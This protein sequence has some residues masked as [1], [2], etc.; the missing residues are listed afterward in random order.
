M[1]IIRVGKDVGFNLTV[2]IINC[3]LDMQEINHILGVLEGREKSRNNRRNCSELKENL[4]C[5]VMKENELSK[6]KTNNNKTKTFY[7]HSRKEG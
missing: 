7:R 6:L 2:D 1:E 3:H 4:R 5:P